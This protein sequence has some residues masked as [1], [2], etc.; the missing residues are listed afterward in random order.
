[1]KPDVVVVGAGLVGTALSRRL[2]ESGLSPR[3]FGPADG[4]P[5]SSHDDS[6]RITR[7]LDG[8]PLWAKLAV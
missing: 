3:C 6:G 1:M 7:I 8:S 2:A 4:P 5:Y